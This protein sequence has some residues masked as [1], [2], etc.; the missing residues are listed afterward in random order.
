MIDSQDKYKLVD[1]KDVVHIDASDKPAQ[2]DALKKGKIVVPIQT[3]RCL[4]AC[5]APEN[6]KCETSANNA[7]KARLVEGKSNAD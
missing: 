5:Y 6:C 1:S 4:I 2:A 3:L 7:N